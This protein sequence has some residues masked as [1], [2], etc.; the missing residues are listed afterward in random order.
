ML[1]HSDTHPVGGT[2]RWRV[3]YSRWLENTAYIVSCTVS[4][5]NASYTVGAVQIL[6]KDVVFTVA[7][8]AL[9]LSVTITVTMTDS[10]GNVLPDTIN[11]VGVSP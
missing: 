7:G 6:G 1:I 10:L 2:I 8:G 11:L 9:N 3:Q 5:S 4:P